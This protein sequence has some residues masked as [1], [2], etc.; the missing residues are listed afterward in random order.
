[1]TGPNKANGTLTLGGY[2]ASKFIPN[3]VPFTMASDIS[4]DLVVGLQ[5]I[6]FNDATTTNDTLLSTRISTFIDSSVPH[7]WL[8]VEACQAFEDSFGIEWN[9]TIERYLVNHTLH[10]Q[11]Q[12]QNAS[13]SF[14]ISDYVNS[15]S[16][17]NITFPYASF[18]LNISDSSVATNQYYFP[19]RQAANESQYTLGRTFLQEA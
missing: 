10:S 2:D 5:S 11:L 12:K 9:S 19:L 14:I 18:D 4:R 16:T 1:M 6:T 15:D 8:P 7:I 13:V 3:G 17:V